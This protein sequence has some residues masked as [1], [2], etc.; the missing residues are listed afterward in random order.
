[1]NVPTNVNDPYLT[2]NKAQM[3][4]F[5]EDLHYKIQNFNYWGRRVTL[6][7]NAEMIFPQV[8]S[9][10]ILEERIE[11][12]KVSWESTLKQNHWSALLSESEVEESAPLEL[13][14]RVAT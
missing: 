14:T 6:G 13:G 1:M 5:A 12:F 7:F 10:I 9:R 8:L 3:L 4:S 2:L 11:I